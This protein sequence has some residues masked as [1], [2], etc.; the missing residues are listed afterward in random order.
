VPAGA[1]NVVATSS[2]VVVEPVG[3]AADRIVE[4]VSAGAANSHVITFNEAAGGG[5]NFACAG[6]G[7][8]TWQSVQAGIRWTVRADPCT[9][10]KLFLALPWRRPSS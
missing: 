6:P 5:F 3:Q 2:A 9:A 1:W 7:I 10:R 8:Y 4:Q